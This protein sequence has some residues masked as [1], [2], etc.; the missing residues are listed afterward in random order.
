MSPA[1]HVRSAPDRLVHKTVA[2]AVA[3]SLRQRILI[4][5]L[6]PGT[7]LRQ[8]ALAE[9]FGISRIPIREA[10]LQLEATGLIKI[11]PHRGAVVSGLSVEEVEDIF[12]LRVQLEPELL[13]LSAR[14]FSEENIL[15]LR[16]LTEEYSAALE[17]GEILRWGELNRR[18]HL[19]LL[20]H[21]ERPRSLNI[22]AGLLQDCD[23]PTRLQ[24]SA[25]GDVAR[26]DR[27]HREILALCEAGKIEAAAD[28]L[29]S[30]IEH[31]AQS[32]I[33]I[34]RRALSA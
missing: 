25:S 32:L 1:A 13:A 22:V 31:A 7:Q 29:R 33:A 16:S 26:A 8:D 34:Y 12:T 20:Q 10:L 17:A 23:R 27:E 28:H 2:A 11:M 21:A 15:E 9:E 6:P 5:E 24:L 30:H 14:R 3:E 18:F 4:G 19:D